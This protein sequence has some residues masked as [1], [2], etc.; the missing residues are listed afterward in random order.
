M[1]KIIKENKVNGNIVCN[2]KLIFE[3]KMPPPM[4]PPIPPMPP[5]PPS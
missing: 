2:G 4:P 1:D 5:M 3:A